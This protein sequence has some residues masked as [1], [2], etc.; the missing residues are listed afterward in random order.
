MKSLLQCRTLVQREMCGA[1]GVHDALMSSSACG[2]MTSQGSATLPLL[3][4]ARINLSPFAT[5]LHA[6][7]C[8][9][10]HFRSSL[11]CFCSMLEH[12]CCYRTGAIH[13]L[14]SGR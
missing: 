7:H 9:G 12:F 14:T 3:N 2:N 8:A 13:P 4:L 10:S 5:L 6:L 1:L 11:V